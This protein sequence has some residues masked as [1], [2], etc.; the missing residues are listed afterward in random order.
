MA[1]LDAVSSRGGTKGLG[2]NTSVISG[3]GIDF[4]ESFLTDCLET[5]WAFWGGG[6]F[7]STGACFCSVKE[8]VLGVLALDCVRE[9]RRSRALIIEVRNGIWLLMAIM[10]GL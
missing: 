9:M 10:K 5:S 8:L 6:N 2:G 3:S 4:G 1:Q 7:V